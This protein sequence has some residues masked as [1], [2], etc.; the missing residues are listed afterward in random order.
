MLQSNDYVK[1]LRF[2]A[3]ALKYSSK[4][5]IISLVCYYL[6]INLDKTIVG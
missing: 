2:S 1:A 3:L 6:G 5:D 4:L